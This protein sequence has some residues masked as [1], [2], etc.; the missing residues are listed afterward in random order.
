MEPKNFFISYNIA[1][2]L[3]ALG[4]RSWLIEEDFSVV[5][6]E[7]DFRPGG[8]FVLEMDK[9][10][11]GAERTIAVL[12]P[13]YL[14]SSFTPSEWAAAFAN[15]PTGDKRSLIPVVV[16]ECELSGLL[17]QIIHI[18]LIGLDADDARK[19][20]VSGIRYA[21]TD[22]L[23]T[24]APPNS[25][26]KPPTSKGNASQSIVGD[27][28]IQAGRDVKIN[29]KEVVR[30]VV[31]REPGE[32]SDAQA[33]R[34]KELVDKIV[35]IQVAAG[36]SSREKAYGEWHKRLK[37]RYKVTSYK[38]LRVEDF[39]DAVSWFKQQSAMLRPKLRRTNNDAW[40]KEYYKAI[41]TRWR[42]LGY[43]KEEIYEFAYQRLEL[44]KPIDSLKQLG[45]RNLKKLSDIISRMS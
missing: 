12:S 19:R 31:V 18:N 32:I 33:A 43:S 11:K 21:V 39:D 37:N 35:E 42:S 8:N 16:R 22:S 34:I 14:G 26:A 28:N 9:A 25:K 41:W 40:R 6:Q 30:N 4:L 27:N 45:E 5:M 7:T 17:K 29:T 3:W 15:D 23:R 44:K 36:K 2:K 24:S 38:K 10:T 13:D 20:F 1:D